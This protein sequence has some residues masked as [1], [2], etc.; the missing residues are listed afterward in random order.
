MANTIDSVPRIGRIPS[1]SSRSSA[2][3]PQTSLPCVSAWI[4]TCGPGRASGER[5]DVADAAVAGGVAREVGKRDLD[6]W[7]RRR[8]RRRRFAG[9]A[10]V[11]QMRS[12]SRCMNDSQS[13][14][15][16]S[17][18]HSF[19][20]CA[21]SMCPGPQMIVA[22]SLPWN[23]DASVPNE[24]LPQVVR[25]A[26]GA[27]EL[28]DFAAA[29]RVEARA[30][31]DKCVEFDVGVGTTPRASRAA[32][33][34][35]KRRTSASSASGSSNG[36][37]RNSKSKLQSRGTMLSAVPPR[38][39][40]VCTVVY[41][42]SY[43]ASNPPR[44]R[45]RRRHLGQERHDLA[46]DL[47]RV[48]A[49]RRQRRVRLVAAHAAAAALLALVRDD[50]LHAGR[51]ADDAAGRLDAARDDVL[52]CRR[53][54]PTQPTS[55]SYDSAKCSGRVETAAQEFGH[56]RESDRRKALH[57]GDAAAVQPVALDRRGERIGIPRLAVD[58]NDVGMA[59]KHDAAGRRVA[60]PRRQRREQI[61]LAAL[62][63]ERE[64]DV[65]AVSGRDSRA[66]SRSA[67]GSTRGWSCRSRSTSGSAA[68]P[69]SCGLTAVA[70][71]GA[72]MLR[73]F[74]VSAGNRIETG[75]R[76]MSMANRQSRRDYAALID[77]L[78]IRSSEAIVRRRD[79]DARARARRR[80]RRRAARCAQTTLPLDKIRLPPG[81]TIEVVARARQCRARWRWAPRARCSSGSMRAGNVY[82]I[83]LQ[84]GAPARVTHRS[85]PGCDEP[86]G[87]AFRDGA[88]Y[89]SAI[90]RILRFDDIERRLD[91]AAERRSS[92]ATAF[93]TSAITAASS[94]P[95]VPTASC[96][97]PSARRATSASPIPIATPTSCA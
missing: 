19:G 57:V 66:P 81:F 83:T 55:S 10:H 26:A 50:Q 41:G 49:V 94:S 76:S 93:R 31:A 59:G 79:G 68:S 78:R 90:D 53:R 39:T 89:V 75:V 8:R 38:I 34:A 42:T 61:R 6:R 48:D 70:A 64:R 44:S 7:R 32:S 46:G 86:V 88:L 47:H 65:D 15:C 97:C 67:P 72:F 37:C 40:P 71:A 2:M 60:V 18:T 28:G 52:R 62:V 4:S 77:R 3:A 22:I 63:V 20:W 12:A 84:P 11:A 25:S 16:S 58:R 56:E 13:A 35:A 9:Q 23:S 45:K 74:D 36:R 24:T 33:V 27:P 91:D 82:A 73:A 21:C 30:C 29:V 1:R 54:T 96:T 80:L 85:L 92:S 14:S 51:L 43:A 87:V 17:D 5:P 95:S 69:I